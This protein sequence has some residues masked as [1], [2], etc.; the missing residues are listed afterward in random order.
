VGVPLVPLG[1]HSAMLV[2]VPRLG[3]G[4]SWMSMGGSSPPVGGF[5]YGCDVSLV[6]PRNHFSVTIGWLNG[7]TER[8]GQVGRDSNFGGAGLFVAGVIHG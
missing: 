6:L 7:P 4:S 5:A 3:Y 2:V 8:P 1:W